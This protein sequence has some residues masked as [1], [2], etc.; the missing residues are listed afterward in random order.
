MASIEINLISDPELRKIA[1]KADSVG[2][3]AYNEILDEN[4]YSLFTKYADEAGISKDLVDKYISG[5]KNT[6]S[7]VDNMKKQIEEKKQELSKKNVEL[8]AK[9]LPCSLGFMLLAMG[10][11]ALGFLGGAF[12]G[13]SILKKCRRPSELLEKT[14]AYSGMIGGSLGGLFGSGAIISKY[15]KSYNYKVKEKK[16]AQE[17]EAFYQQ[18]VKPLEEQL[19]QMEG[20][21]DLLCKQLEREKAEKLTMSK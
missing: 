14:L 6:Q 13:F 4:E 5:Q 16:A 3:N 21:Y 10:G 20:K 1:R 12:V 8:N 11:M 19:A 15:Q 2:E 9:G 18:E 17:K 7:Q